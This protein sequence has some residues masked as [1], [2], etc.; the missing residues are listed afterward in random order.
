METSEKTIEAGA[1]FL[2][3]VAFVVFEVFEVDAAM[4][5]DAVERILAGF[6]E[7][8]EVLAGHAE[9]IGGGLGGEGFVFGQDEDG[10]TLADF[11]GDFNEGFEQWFGERIF[12]A[13]GTFEVKVLGLLR[14]VGEVEDRLELIEFS[15]R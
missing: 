9:V 6:D 7:G 12:D 8:D 5:G 3:A 4:A 1:A 15:A 11:V 13:V 14:M 2:V 10:F